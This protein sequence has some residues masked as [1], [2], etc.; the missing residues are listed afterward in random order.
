M[1]FATILNLF[2]IF[3]F[4]VFWLMAFFILYHLTRF[5][6]GVFPKRLAALF[7]GGAVVLSSAVFLSYSAANI[8]SLFT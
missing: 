5:G 1:P 2:L 4:V 8:S 6:V 7:L 3:L